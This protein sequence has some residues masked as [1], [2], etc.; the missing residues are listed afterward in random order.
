MSQSFISSTKVLED[1]Y[2]GQEL[3]RANGFAIRAFS[4]LTIIMALVPLTSFIRIQQV[5]PC[6]LILISIVF[7]AF[8]VVNSSIWDSEVHTQ[9]YN[10]AGICHIEAPLRQPL[11]LAFSLAMVLMPWKLIETLRSRKAVHKNRIWRDIIVVWGIPLLFTLPFQYFVMTNIF[12]VLPGFG[13]VPEFDNSWLSLVIV[14]IWWPLLLFLTLVLAV[15][16]CVMIHRK[17]IEISNSLNDNSSRVTQRT[18]I[19][20]YV[21]AIIIIAIY[22][23]VQFI[24]IL[25]FVPTHYERRTFALEDSKDWNLPSF[26]HTSYDPQIQYQPWAYISINLLMFL[27][28]GISEEAQ[29][30]YWRALQKIGLGKIFPIFNGPLPC[31]SSKSPLVYGDLVGLITRWFERRKQNDLEKFL[32]YEPESKPENSSECSRSEYTQ[33]TANEFKIPESPDSVQACCK[34]HRKE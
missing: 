22:F 6:S 23:P 10:G 5:G 26:Y 28:Y 3:N 1:H 34:E 25:R 21:M 16:M 33:D 9:W 11:T 20:L 12:S 27:F 17:R 30:L 19:K 18:F 14:Y 8:A 31:R 29:S 13:C 32:E 24:F 15:L 7:S 4:V 2:V